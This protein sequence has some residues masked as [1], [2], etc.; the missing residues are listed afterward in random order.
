MSPGGTEFYGN[1]RKVSRP[2]EKLSEVD[3]RSPGYTESLRKL[4]EGLV[5]YKGLTEVYKRYLGRTESRQ[6]FTGVLAA[7]KVDRICIESRQHKIFMEVDRMS[8][9]RT[10]S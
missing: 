2:Q 1:R 4:T 9:S 7:K 6:N 3:G 10:G 5:V 8:L